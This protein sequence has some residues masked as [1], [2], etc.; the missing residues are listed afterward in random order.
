MPSYRSCR[1]RT[2]RFHPKPIYFFFTNYFNG[3]AAVFN[4]AENAAWKALC[5]ALEWFSRFAPTLHR[6]APFRQRIVSS[7]DVPALAEPLPASFHR[8]TTHRLRRQRER[9]VT[10]FFCGA[11]NSA[12]T[13]MTMRSGTRGARAP[14]TA[15]NRRR[16][17][18]R[19]SKPNARTMRARR[20]EKA[21]ITSTTAPSPAGIRP[22]RVSPFGSR[23]SGLAIRVSPFGTCPFGMRRCEYTRL[24]GAR[25]DHVYSDSMR[26]Q[27]RISRYRC[28]PLRT[29]RIAS[30]VRTANARATGPDAKTPA[31]AGVIVQSNWG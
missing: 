23:R 8:R 15:R 24:S 25:S 28:R 10:N 26:F 14:T 18:Q 6:R 5:T 27:R 21:R 29:A 4:I 12:M 13:L 11:S 2:V 31:G 1:S 17:T 19:A 30:R 3:L 9:A 22:I 16:A 20:L 7:V